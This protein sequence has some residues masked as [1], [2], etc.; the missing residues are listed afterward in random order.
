[1]ETTLKI[2]IAG[3]CLALSLSLSTVT[4]AQTPPPAPPATLQDAETAYVDYLRREGYAPTIIKRDAGF[5]VQFKIEGVTHFIFARGSPLYF[6]LM[7]SVATFDNKDEDMKRA[8]EA[9]NSVNSRIAVAKAHVVKS[10]ASS[11]AWVTYETYFSSSPKEIDRVFPTAVR[12]SASAA[13]HFTER[14]AP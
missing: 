13:K 12:V 3:I 1:M 6:R 7:R 11:V 8:L 14:Y 10:A 9:A 2:A 5:D 4:S